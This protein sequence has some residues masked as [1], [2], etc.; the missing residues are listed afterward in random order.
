MHSYILNA[1][2]DP[3][4][5]PVPPEN[6]SEEKDEENNEIFNQLNDS[7]LKVP[8]RRPPSLKTY[9]CLQC[10]EPSCTVITPCSGAYQVSLSFS[11]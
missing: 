2:E 6:L 5:P 4:E 1:G 11:Y 10:E 7:L 3:P 8:F 9:T